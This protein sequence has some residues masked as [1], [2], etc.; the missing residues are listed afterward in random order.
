MKVQHGSI[1][2]H[3]FK[4]TL[5]ELLVV[6]AIIAILASM[7]LPALNKARGKAKAISCANN[8]KQNM[9]NLQ[10]YADDYDGYMWCNIGGLALQG[11]YFWTQH[12]DRAGLFKEDTSYCPAAAP[13]KYQLSFNYGVTYRTTFCKLLLE[14]R[15]RKNDAT[16][17]NALN[18]FATIPEML[19]TLHRTVKVQYL[20]WNWNLSSSASLRHSN[21]A[22]AGMLDGHVEPLGKYELGVPTQYYIGNGADNATFWTY[23]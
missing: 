21:K 19:D 20:F 8:I 11:K 17:K 7:L 22:N 18:T 23:E 13:Y 9:L 12:L 15:R 4:F 5:I 2:K 1:V 6:I 3:Q 10:M 16:Y 14:P